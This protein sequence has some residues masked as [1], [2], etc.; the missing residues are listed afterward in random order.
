MT[1]FYKQIIDLTTNQISKNQIFRSDN[2]FIP[3]DP[4]NT[5]YQNFKKDLQS[6][7]TLQDADGN[8]MTADQITTFL[9]SLK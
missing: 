2:W 9:G 6:G 4:A 5:D 8:T 1:I 3:L 7:A